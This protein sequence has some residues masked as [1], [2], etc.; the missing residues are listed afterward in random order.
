MATYDELL[1]EG[2]YESRVWIDDELL[3]DEGIT[4]L[5]SS[6]EPALP[7]MRNISV[8]I[9]GRHG[10]YDFG[11]YLEPREFTLNVVF[12][13]KSYSDLKRQIRSFN[14][15]FI[16]E[17]GRPKTVTLRF[18]DEV[19]K[20]Y[21]VRLT[22]GIPVERAAERGF[23]PLSLTAFDPYAYSTVMAD[24][25]VW[26][27][28]V[29]TFEWNYLLG[30]G[31]TGGGFTVTRPQTIPIYVDGEA[32]R[33]VIE[34]NGTANNLT[35]SANGKSFKLPNFSATKWI[36]DGENYVVKRNGNEEL[37][38]MTGDFIELMHGENDVIISGSSMDFELTIKYRDK[39]I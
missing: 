1:H 18:G 28:E 15:K 30:M 36:I 21:Y 23:L 3:Q 4:V 33:P 24:E 7:S 9:P 14:R 10:S 13:R 31:G 39:Y 22:E 6:E 34:I 27:S 26:G 5:L 11:A 19:D 37:S 2:L 8:T 12:P 32:L 29:I 38:A 17:Y 25:V 16:D 20:F 35:I